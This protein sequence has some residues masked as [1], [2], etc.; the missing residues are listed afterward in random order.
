MK[1]ETAYQ[2]KC[3]LFARP[4]LIF[5]KHGSAL[6]PHIAPTRAPITRCEN[7][8]DTFNVC[9]EGGKNDRQNLIEDI[10]TCIHFSL[11]NYIHHISTKNRKIRTSSMRNLK[12]TIR[13]FIPQK[14]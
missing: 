5:L 1:T 10:V 3:D 8:R 2:R 13:S 6:L 7:T 4:R 9:A 11:Y 12:E 14:L